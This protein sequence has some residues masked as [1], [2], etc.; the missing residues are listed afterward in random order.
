MNV[1]KNVKIEALFDL[2]EKNVF[3]L[4]KPPS[5]IS[6]ASAILVKIVIHYTCMCSHLLMF[7]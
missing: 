7:S 2:E 6:H 1:I 5:N 4:N 3:S